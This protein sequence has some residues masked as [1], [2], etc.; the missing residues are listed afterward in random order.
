MT[1]WTLAIRSLRYHARV[2]A[3][4]VAGVAAATA[5]LV[6]ALLV[7]DTVRFSLRSLT[8]ERLGRVD[9][10]LLSQD[11]FRAD[12]VEKLRERRLREDNDD[13]IRGVAPA[14]VLLQSMLV[15]PETRRR[16]GRV[17]ILATDESFWELRSPGTP[18]PERLPDDFEIVINQT[19]A[20]A[21]EL[22][23]GDTV[24]LR[25]P[26]GSG[27][28]PADSP[29]GKKQDLVKRLPELKV[30]E[31]LPDRGFGRFQIF[32]SQRS[33]RNVFVS[34]AALREV[35]EIAQRWNALFV[36]GLTAVP[37]S[38]AEATILDSLQLELPDIGLHL[39]R[40]SYPPAGTGDE[41]VARA[42]DYYALWSDRMLMRPGVDSAVKKSVGRH[43]TD[44]LTY[45]AN[46]IEPYADRRG[47]GPAGRPV[48][49]SLVTAIDPSDR[50]VLRDLSGGRIEE[51]G[52]DRIVLTSWLAEQLGAAVGDRITLTFFDPESPGGELLERKVEL[53]VQ[54][55]TPLTRPTE[56]Y[57]PDRRLEFADM[58][59][60]VNDPWLAPPVRG[61]SD[62]ESIDDWDVPFPIDYRLVRPADEDY[63]KWYATTPK[64]FVSLEQGRKLWGSRFGRT[65]SWR[66]DIDAGE[67]DAAVAQMIERAIDWR[68]VGLV[69][70][71]LRLRQVEA[72]KGTTPFGVLFLSLSM[73]VI[74][75]ALL[76]VALL[77]RLG[78]SQRATS[79]GVLS[80]V[81]FP[82]R[83]L[84][85]WFLREEL[86][87]ASCGA[88]LGTVM[89]VG[90]A[91]L[92]VWLLSTVWVGAITV[93]FLRF[94]MAWGSLVGGLF[95]GLVVCTLTM[96]WGVRGALRRPPLLLLRGSIE[97]T[98]G[99]RV[100]RGLWWSVAAGCWVLAVVFAIIAATTGGMTQAGSFVGAGFL[101]LSGSL[102]AL[103]SWLHGRP[104]RVDPLLGDSPLW[105]WAVRSLTRRPERSM[106][107]IGL[108]S[109][110]SFL[111]VAMGAF[112]MQPTDEGT[113]G[114]ELMGE[115]S[116]PI[117]ADWRS[118]IDEVFTKRVGFAG[119]VVYR[120]RLREG[121][122]ASCTNLYRPSQPRILGVTDDFIAAATR[123]D[124][125]RFRWAGVEGDQ[126]IQRHPWRVLDHSAETD[127]D[128]VPV[129]LDRNTAMYSLQMYGGI[130][131]EFSLDYDGRT[132]RFRV[133]GL[134]ADSVLQ[135]VLLIGESD[136][137]RLFPHES[138]YRF[139]LI[140]V[141]RGA[142]VSVR[143]SLEERFADE[144][145]ELTPTR[146]VL[147]QLLAVQ[148]T[149]L[150]T[151][152]ALGALALLL[153]TFGVATVQFRNVLERRGELALL[154][155]IG[156]YVG[157]LAGVVLREN[158]V[159]LSAGL[160][161]GVLCAL[162]AVLPY[163]WFSGSR[164]P[165]GQWA[166]MLLAV[167]IVGAL[168][169]LI[170]V[171][172]VLRLPLLASLRNE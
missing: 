98:A 21:L 114:F 63:W 39:R 32:P 97:L 89:G 80:A 126:E 129:V 59:P 123:R 169:G 111:I 65:T 22:E 162:V 53:V 91:K 152:Q 130:G 4:V 6:G 67:S 144:G 62:R 142:E 163:Q 132:I 149:Y 24:T 110:S 153:G 113:G 64:A 13:S 87:V 9:Y 11:F 141:P 84:L 15:V 136:F 156:F 145:L 107:T 42:Y 18:R 8:E 137:T 34:P 138:G 147:A 155:A 17:T 55:V 27:D 78:L 51:I 61:F 157:R 45:L 140:D 172:A 47:E 115:S 100:K 66:I 99:R 43:G 83:R 46:L 16:A 154:R 95:A 41:G 26:G 37:S 171:R 143:R 139:F 159:L 20:D 23:Q 44:V 101:L 135:G 36:S 52:G 7:G 38:K 76:L 88:L 40:I 30:I 1:L 54:A 5:V 3:V 105:R 75:A 79:L 146:S 77:F 119:P 33:P 166:A 58:P 68:Q 86:A 70:H 118:T 106:L 103:W 131:E 125:N 85:G 109:A 92:M 165:L 134:L 167:W 28:I 117:Y 128:I 133:V 121:D 14:I 124:T 73:F 71:P 12:R 57:L 170:A 93:P 104:Y 108:I 25:L 161:I 74:V 112:Q 96:V 48:P 31:I 168:A 150:Q 69:V 56:P 120:W 102:A 164:V 82:R 72:S 50:F 160:G 127:R 90:Y 81:G 35:L 158:L 116:T 19:L 148:N 60:A 151:F 122:E 2:H 29:F 49:Y 10:L 94:H